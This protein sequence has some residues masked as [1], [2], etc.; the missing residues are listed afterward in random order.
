[1]RARQ[2]LSSP[3]S[4]SRVMH[5]GYF[6]HDGARGLECLCGLH[7]DVAHLLLQR[8]ADADI[9]HQADAHLRGDFSSAFQL[10][11]SGG[12]LMPSRRS[13]RDSTLIINAASSTVRVIGPATRPT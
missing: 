10:M 11:L 3:S 8:L 6:G 5:A 12:R 7:R 4:I 2:K 13:G 1:M 9:E